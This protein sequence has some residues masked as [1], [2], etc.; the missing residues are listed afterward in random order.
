MRYQGENSLRDLPRRRPLTISLARL[1][2]PVILFG[3]D[4]HLGVIHRQT[5]RNLAVDQD[6]VQLFRRSIGIQSPVEVFDLIADVDTSHFVILENGEGPVD[7]ELRVGAEPVEPGLRRSRAIVE[8]SAGGMLRR[9]PG[10]GETG[11]A[12]SGTRASRLRMTT[13]RHPID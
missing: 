10:T 11:G 4:H 6:R 1:Q 12:G 9:S 13:I 7:Q 5:L 3:P 8:R 2:N